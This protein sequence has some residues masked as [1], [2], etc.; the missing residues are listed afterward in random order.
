MENS[1][2]PSMIRSS[3][4]PLTL[5]IIGGGQACTIF[6]E[7][8]KKKPF[9]YLDLKIAGV[10]DIDPDAKGL[11]LARSMGIY[12]TDNYHDLFTIENLDGI[13][14]LTNDKDLLLDLV[15]HKPEDVGILEHNIGR[16]FTTFFDINDRLNIAEKQIAIEKMITDFLIHRKPVL[17]AAEAQCAVRATG[18]RIFLAG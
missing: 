8:F 3:K 17:N 5:A 11:L 16:L 14:E 9:P 12:T 4:I 10:C 18:R 15:K 2:D 6:L 1:P 7:L 13:I